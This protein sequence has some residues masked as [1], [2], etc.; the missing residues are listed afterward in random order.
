RRQDLLQFALARLLDLLDLSGLLLQRLLV[1]AG[2]LAV[3]VELLHHRRELRFEL[4]AAC[5][6]LVDLRLVGRLALLLRR[7]VGVGIGDN[8]RKADDAYAAGVLRRSRRREDHRGRS[9]R[10]HETGRED[11]L[12]KVLHQNWVPTLKVKV[13]VSSPG[14]F[15]STWAKSMRNGPKGEFQ[16]TPMPTEIR[17]LAVSPRK[18]SWNGFATL[19]IAGSF[20]LPAASVG[21]VVVFV[22]SVGSMKS[23]SPSPLRNWRWTPS[24]NGALWSI[25]RVTLNSAP[26]S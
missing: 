14:S 5:L 18:T 25:G 24:G 20:G 19:Y 13:F 3:G 8:G 12:E 16:F 4:L 23:G 6:G 9:R 2:G 21:S 17:G 22:S 11:R 1:R 15:L 7:L 10:E 26:T